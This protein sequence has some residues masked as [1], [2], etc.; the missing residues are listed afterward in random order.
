M[1]LLDF[2]VRKNW[3]IIM[4]R[5]LHLI[6]KILLKIEEEY[7]NT[8]LFGLKIEGY[9]TQQIANHVELLYG[10]GLISYYKGQYGGNKLWTFT[11]GNLTNEGFNYLDTIRDTDDLESHKH[12][13]VYYDYS[14]KIG[15]KNKI[16]HTAISTGD[17]DGEE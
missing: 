16:G 4:K 1:Y 12:F 15:D 10:E 17:N 6:K 5:D 9:T 8:T 11:V 7:E 3:G 14:I 2:I 13:N